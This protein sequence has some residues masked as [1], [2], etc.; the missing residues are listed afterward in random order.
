MLEIGSWKGGTLFLFSR[1]VDSDAKI[2]SLDLPGGDFGGGSNDYKGPFF[3]N[4][5]CGNQEIHLFRAD[6]HLPLSLQNIRA[7]LREGQL[8]FLFI[9]G[10]HTYKG[11]KQDFEMYSPLV[12]KGGLIAFHD[13]CRHPPETGCDVFTF[14]KEIKHS[15]PHEELIKNPK[16]N[17]AGIGL[18]YI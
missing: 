9:D 4:F 17:W 15:Y 5:A 1:V 6:S 16:Q 11:V 8:D 7:I 13:I 18:L 14:W 12:R 2:L 3:K 10:D